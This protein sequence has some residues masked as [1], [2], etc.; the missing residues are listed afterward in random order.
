MATNTTAA[1][2]RQVLDYRDLESEL[3]N[4]VSMSEVACDMFEQAQGIA[5]R[6]ADGIVLCD[7]EVRLLSFAIHHANSLAHDLMK[8]WKAVHD[9][10]VA[11]NRKGASA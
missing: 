6:R 1:G 8:K 9:S 4:A 2:G 11:A 5:N 7:E 10:N 3:H